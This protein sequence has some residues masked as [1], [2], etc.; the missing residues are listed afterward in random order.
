A[1]AEVRSKETTRAP[2]RPFF[3]AASGLPLADQPNALVQFG[4]KR[5]GL[6]RIRLRVGG[7]FCTEQLAHELRRRRTV[8]LA[9]R[10]GDGGESHGGFLDVSKCRKATMKVV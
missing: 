8:R 9:F 1:T 3:Q 5:L 6:R 4:R 7:L 10:E 2:R